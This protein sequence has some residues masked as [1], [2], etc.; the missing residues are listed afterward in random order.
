MKRRGFRIA[1]D[2]FGTGHSNIDRLLDLSVDFVKIDRKLVQSTG[3]N[4]R[5]LVDGIVR[6]IG[7]TD[8][9]IVGEGIETD[10]HARFARQIG[11]S[12]GQGWFYGKEIPIR[13]L[14]RRFETRNRFVP[15]L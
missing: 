8:I 9:R 1:V 6:A 5:N 10:S 2:D 7:R 13:E 12:S 3:Q 11:C 14:S 4:N 15:N